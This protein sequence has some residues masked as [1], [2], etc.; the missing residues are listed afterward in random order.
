MLIKPDVQKFAKIKV[1]GLGGG[2]SNSLNSM[3][4][5][6]QIQGVEFVAINTDAQALMNNQSPTKVQI[7]E[8]LTKGLGSGGDPEVGRQAAEESTQKLQ[9]VL[10][11]ADMVFLTAGMGGG[12]GTGSIP[13]VAQIAKNAGALTVAVVTKPFAFEGTRR[14]MVA[15]EGVETLKDKVDALII[16][17]NQ[18]LLETVEKNMTLQEAFKLADSV[19]GQGVQG[20][21]DLIVI[22]GLINVDFADVKTIMSN[23]GSALM[24]IG[25]AG[26]ENRAAAAAR[27]AISSPLLEVSIEGAKGVLFNIVGGPDL[28]MTEVNEAAQI[29]AQAADPDA[30]II[31]GATIKDDQLD[32]IK[33]SV[34]ATGFDETRR[35]LREYVGTG[36]GSSSLGVQPKTW[37]DTTTPQVDEEEIPQETEQVNEE[38]KD[39]EIEKEEENL[40][41]P[42]FLRSN[43]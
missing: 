5:L 18:R 23:A 19:L 4:S 2:G 16:I 10:T 15:E 34:I 14:M 11:D 17:P 37:S 22:P 30:N 41:I 36:I 13:I 29:I 43:R 31:F 24:G 32:Q 21:S 42:A 1:I 3:I 20:I 7:G 28:S 40:E 27:M 9:D 6:Q 33:V 12:T 38:E 8:T 39:K 35:R 26:G 25:M